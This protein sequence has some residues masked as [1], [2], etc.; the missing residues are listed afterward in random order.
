M[1]VRGGK[2]GETRGSV[3][4]HVVDCVGRP[5]FSGAVTLSNFIDHYTKGCYTRTARGTYDGMSYVD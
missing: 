3:R 5:F 1:D 2:L 4:R